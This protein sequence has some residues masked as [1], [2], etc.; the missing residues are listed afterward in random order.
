MNIFLLWEQTFHGNPIL[1]DIFQDN[2]DAIEA[3]K[4]HHRLYPCTRTDIEVRRL[5]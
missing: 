3:E 4:E 1:I 2:A 5:K